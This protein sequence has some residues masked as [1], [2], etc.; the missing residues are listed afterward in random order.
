MST[1]TAQPTFDL[2]DEY[3]QH[4]IAMCRAQSTIDTYID[5]LRRM[6]RGLPYG[7]LSACEEELHAWVFTDSHGDAH[8]KLCRIIVNGFFAWACSRG[9]GERGVDFNP[10]ADLPM[11]SAPEGRPNPVTPEEKLEL[12]ARAERPYRDWFDIAL[13]SGARCTEISNLDREHITERRTLLRGKGGKS[14][15]V[16]THRVVWEVAQQLPPGPV[17]VETRGPRRG[18]RL[19]RKQVSRRG[20]YYLQR[21][22]GLDGVHMHR[23]R[24]T[25]GTE[26]YRSTR[27]IMAVRKLLGHANVATTQIY[28]AT[29]DDALDRA[30]A[31]L[32]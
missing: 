11:I 31:G 26:A 12:L 27:D 18:Q 28:V 15:L 13:F 29:G 32:A 21:V 8:R 20:N 19:D 3:Q 10:A 4:L 5:T 25:F 23:L 2:I 9:P 6:D 24:S 30:V 1:V 14:R 16:P 17:A 22:L 7:L